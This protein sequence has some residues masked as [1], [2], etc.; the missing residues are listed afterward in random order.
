EIPP[1][2][3]TQREAEQGIVLFKALTSISHLSD[4]ID[5]SDN[6]I[7]WGNMMLEL[8]GNGHYAIGWDYEHE[9]QISFYEAFETAWHIFEVIR[10]YR[11]LGTAQAITF[12]QR[13][14]IAGI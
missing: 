5:V 10:I 2:S 11:K 1:P 14:L 8:E 7:L 9:E 4:A 12:V 6:A 3:R 13:I